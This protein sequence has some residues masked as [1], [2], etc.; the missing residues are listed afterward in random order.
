MRDFL[1]LLWLMMKNV[2]KPQRQRAFPNVKFTFENLTNVNNL[3]QPSP[4]RFHVFELPQVV[5]EVHP[6]R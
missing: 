2:G 5:C 1:I 3:S 6:Y 4:A